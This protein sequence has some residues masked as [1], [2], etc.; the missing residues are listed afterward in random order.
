MPLAGMNALSFLQYS[1][2][3]SWATEG[4]PGLRKKPVFS[5]IQKDSL[6]EQEETERHWLTQVH[7]KNGH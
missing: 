7:L 4:T 6:L 5:I 2:T 1:D 3:A